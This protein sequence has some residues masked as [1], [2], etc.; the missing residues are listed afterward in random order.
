MGSY[1]WRVYSIPII[2]NGFGIGIAFGIGIEAQPL[3]TSTMTNKIRKNSAILSDL[4]N[5]K[6]SPLDLDYF[7]LYKGFCQAFPAMS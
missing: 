7:T 5:L 2:A 4:F 1:L 6:V 3:N